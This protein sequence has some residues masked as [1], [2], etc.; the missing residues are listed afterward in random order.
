MSRLDNNGVIAKYLTTS[1]AADYLRLRPRTLTQMR[2]LHTGPPYCKLGGKVVYNIMRLDE[3][4]N[5]NS[6]DP[7]AAR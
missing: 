2:W 3:W 1:E 5:D 7:K 4:A 6:Y